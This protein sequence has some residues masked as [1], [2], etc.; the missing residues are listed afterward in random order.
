MWRYQNSSGEKKKEQNYSNSSRPQRMWPGSVCRQAQHA[1]T[2]THTHTHTNTHK[3]DKGNLAAITAQHH[4]LIAG[5]MRVSDRTK[6][7][8]HFHLD[9]AIFLFSLRTLRPLCNMS[10]NN[11][12]NIWNTVVEEVCIW[13]TYMSISNLQVL[14]NF[15]DIQGDH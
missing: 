1:I 4:R 13:K 9:E 7:Q 12:K 10:L 6:I 5:K 11:D 8:V 3:E 2:H 15:S 14:P